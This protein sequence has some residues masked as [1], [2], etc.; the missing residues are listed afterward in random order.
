[1]RNGYMSLRDDRM[2]KNYKE[3]VQDNQLAKDEKD[4]LGN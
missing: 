3:K 2:M 4:T 1:M